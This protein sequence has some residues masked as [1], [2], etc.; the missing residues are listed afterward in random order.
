MRKTAIPDLLENIEIK[1]ALVSIDAMGCHSNIAAQIR[2]NQA[3]YLLALKQNQK[4]VYEEVHDWMQARK[5][6]FDKD[7]Q[8][9][10]VG[11]RIEKR[12]TYVC[13]DLRF[14]DELFGWKDCQRVVMVE[15]QRSFKNDPSSNSFKTRFY[16]SSAA[17]NAAYF[18]L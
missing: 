12:T 4:G 14:I 3:D 6:S 2:E 1:G 13:S 16:V 7:V 8:T 9:D 5:E 10:Y 15:C 11:G 17:R 18:G